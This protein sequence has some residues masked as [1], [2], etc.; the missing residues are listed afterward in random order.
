MVS[1]LEN[2]INL[3]Q[4]THTQ[5]PQHKNCSLPLDSAGNSEPA[6]YRAISGVFCLRFH[7]WLS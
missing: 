2:E 1:S 4:H 5:S 7:L 3:K 6:L